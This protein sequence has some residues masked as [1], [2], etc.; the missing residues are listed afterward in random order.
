MTHAIDGN[1]EQPSGKAWFPVKWVQHNPLFFS[2][3]K[4]RWIGYVMNIYL[5]GAECGRSQLNENI[6]LSISLK[7]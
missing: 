2:Y 1:L 6:L 7:L 5:L 3:A 4:M